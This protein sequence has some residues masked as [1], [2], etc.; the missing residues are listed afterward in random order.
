MKSS[1]D[2]IRPWALWRPRAARWRWP[3][4]RAPG[5]SAGQP[6]AAAI[7][8][9]Y[10]RTKATYVFWM[11][12]DVAGDPT[13]SAALRA[14]DPAADV[15]AQDA[16]RGYGSSA[17]PSSF[18]QLLEQAG[19]RRDLSW[20]FADWVDADKGLPDLT[21]LG[22]FP[23]HSLGGQLAGGRQHGQSRLCLG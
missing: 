15:S 21:I 14:Y 8:P 17:G 13:L 3:S 10:Y 18:E 4:R 20:F 22:V 19:T 6:L 16:S 12:R 5:Q 7:S 1:A 9:V 23:H 2:A 11:L